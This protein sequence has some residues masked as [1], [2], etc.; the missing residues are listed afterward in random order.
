MRTLAFEGAALIGAALIFSTNACAIEHRHWECG[1]DRLFRG[2]DVN[3]S[4]DNG[5]ITFTDEESCES[6]QITDDYNLVVNERIVHL[7]R[8]QQRLVETYHSRFSSLTDDA[9]ELAKDA[10]KIGLDGAKLGA[11][12]VLGVLRLLSSDYDS[13]DLEADLGHKGS[14]IEQKAERL[15]RRGERLEKRAQSLERLHRELR[16]SIRELNELEWF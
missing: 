9:I 2:D 12:A 14:K 8:H 1:Q 15:E 6:V 7:D 11:F 4:I 3:V 13:D 5:C 10:V 16:K